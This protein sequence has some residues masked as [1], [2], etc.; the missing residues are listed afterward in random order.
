[1][2]TLESTKD[3]PALLGTS[4]KAVVSSVYNQETQVLTCQHQCS[5]GGKGKDAKRYQV[6][7]RFDM[8]DVTEVELIEKLASEILKVKFRANIDFANLADLSDTDNQ[9]YI[10]RDM[11]DNSKSRRSDPVGK[12][13]KNLNNLDSTQLDEIIRLAQE[14]KDKAQES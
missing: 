12:V 13:K 14:A 11:L 7:T 5:Q 10:V 8:T 9:T 3:V 2:E 1:M 4:Q 6:T